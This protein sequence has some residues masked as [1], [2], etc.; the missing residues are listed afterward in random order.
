MMRD[1]SMQ[2][3]DSVHFLKCSWARTNDKL[4]VIWGGS[5]IRRA[6]EVKAYPAEG[7][8]QYTHLERL[9]AYA[10]DLNPDEGTGQYLK[11]VEL[12]NVCC[13]NLPE[14]HYALGLAIRRLR[15]RPD[16]VSSFL[17]GA[18]LPI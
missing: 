5:P 15:C 14:L 3:T 16:V 17:A 6:S 10:P 18:G 7:A 1:D 11:H 8:A 9:P 4:L 13:M 2:A 12:R